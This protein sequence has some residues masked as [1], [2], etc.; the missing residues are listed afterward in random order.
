MGVGLPGVEA[1]EE[2]QLPGAKPGEH[3][4]THTRLFASKHLPSTGRDW[5][6]TPEKIESGKRL[7]PED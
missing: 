3:E 6:P 2:S 5:V 1:E 7:R 4:R